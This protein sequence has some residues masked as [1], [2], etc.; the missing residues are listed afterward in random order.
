MKKIVFLGPPGCG[1]GTQSKILVE[2][3]NFFQLSTGDLLREQTSDKNSQYG[4]DI[5]EIMKKGELVTDEIVINLIIDKICFEENFLYPWSWPGLL[6][7][8]PIE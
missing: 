3:F 1:K 2:K 5:I 6:I 4:K 8:I 7:S